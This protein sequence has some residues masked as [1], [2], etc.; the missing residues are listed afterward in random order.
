MRGLSLHNEATG[1]VRFILQSQLL[2]KE[3]VIHA[4]TIR[5]GCHQE[6]PSEPIDLA[7]ELQKAGDAC[8]AK[9]K[10]S[11]QTKAYWP[12][13]NEWNNPVGKPPGQCLISAATRRGLQ[14]THLQT[15]PHANPH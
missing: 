10:P 8:S 11:M 4:N 9:V 6:V 5:G 3:R 2:C 15:Q 12:F 1:Q 13:W 7:P 14:A